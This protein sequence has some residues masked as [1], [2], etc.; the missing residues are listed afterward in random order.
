MALAG[1]HVISES[2]ILPTNL[3][4]YLDAFDGLSVL[5]VGVRCP[6]ELAER[7]E[8]ARA[9][10]E[11]HQGQ[12]IDLRVPEFEL[13]HSHGPYDVEV[14]TSITSVADAVGLIRARLSSP[15]A[16]F[17]ALQARHRR[18]GGLGQK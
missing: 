16:A 13:V 7:R 9:P 11:R 8:R 18:A 14:D 5:L 6:L 2:V 1:H 10:A 15:P 4:T 3:K 12:P 17:E